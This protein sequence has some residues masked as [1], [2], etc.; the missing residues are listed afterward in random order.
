V[1]LKVLIIPEDPTQNGYIL[2]PLIE[3]ILCDVGKERAQ[4]TVLTNPRL[5][6][7]DH[8]VKAIVEE[9]PSRYKYWDIW[10]FMPDADRASDEGMRALEN[11][12]LEKNINLLC[13]AARPEVEIFAC[14]GYRS[15]LRAQWSEVRSSDRMKED[16]FKPLLEE[17]GDKRRAGGGRDL[18]IAHS[19]ANM[20]AMYRL[21]PELADLRDRCRDIVG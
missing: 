14:V 7:Y 2:K 8:A 5:Q 20:Q 15:E 18:L 9:L 6:G 12:M 1:S 10:L 19:L 3:A 4:V 16:F 13:C 11:K 21:C 17:R